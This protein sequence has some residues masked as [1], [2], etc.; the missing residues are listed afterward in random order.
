M[1][2]QYTPVYKTIIYR[3]KIRHLQRPQSLFQY[4]TNTR[5]LRKQN[6]LALG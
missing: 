3:Q 1:E 5:L 2:V 6:N 4:P